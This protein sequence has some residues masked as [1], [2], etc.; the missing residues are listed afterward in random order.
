MNLNIVAEA[1]SVRDFMANKIEIHIRN[2]KVI[3]GQRIIEPVSDGIVR[4]Q[5]LS[6]KVL[7]TEKIMTEADKLALETVNEFAEE[8]GLLVKVYDVLSY[9]GRLR[10]ILRGIRR[11][12]TVLIGKGRIEGVLSSDN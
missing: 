5:C 7:G 1:F 9:K 3:V 2:E 12:P 8:K 11:T 4:H 6:K 10:A